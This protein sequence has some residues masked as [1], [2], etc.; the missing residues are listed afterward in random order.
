M[1]SELLAKSMLW[2]GAFLFPISIEFIKNSIMVPTVLYSAIKSKKRAKSTETPL[3][4]LL[5]PVYNSAKTL[6]MCLDSVA[7][8]TYPADKIEIF[9]LNNGQDDGSHEIFQS[10]HNEHPELNMWWLDTKAGKSKALNKG[11]FLSKGKYIINI[12][13]D[14]WL[15]KEALSN[16][17]SRFETSP[18]ISCMT[19]VVLTDPHLIEQTKSK[20][21]KR[22]QKCEFFEYIESFLVG[23]N[24]QSTTNNLYTLA[25]AFSCFR[26]EVIGKTSLYNF[27]TLGEDT[28]M[29]LQ[30]RNQEKGK[31]ALCENAFIYV[32]PI[33]SLD[34]L[35]MQ[36]QR[37][38]R[39]VIEMAQMF[40]EYH[41]GGIV[42]L[43]KKPLMRLFILD[44]TLLLLRAI[45]VSTLVYFL[46]INYPIPYLVAGLA[47]LYA[48]YI[49]NSLLYQRM[50]LLFIDKS[51]PIRSYIKKNQYVS[52]GMMSY[53]FLLFL[54]R[55]AGIVNSL[56][57]EA[58]WYAKPL[59]QEFN[60]VKAMFSFKKLRKN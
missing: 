60:E 44:H 52:F 27:D 53:R 7:N 24:F 31:I 36:R 26:R 46:T 20:S 34:K 9:L 59:S 39:S 22:L 21:L 19:G 17:V 42:D 37:W 3:I 51:S 47:M 18:D 55:L 54:T 11:I 56:T 12:D 28:H 14:G 16:V 33:E 49:G 32:D 35:Y 4:S 25:G 29:T 23:R 48:I 45:W 58:K 15:D 10:F 40:K 57:S 30:V 2:G 5:I 43:F 8:Q 13:S 50:A 6:K 38:Q 41:T 1:L